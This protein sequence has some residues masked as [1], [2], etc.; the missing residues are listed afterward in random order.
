M[1]DSSAIIAVILDEP[2][3]SIVM[4][5]LADALVSAPMVAEAYAVILRKM[6]T[7]RSVD[8]FFD[9]KGVKVVPLSFDQAKMAGHYE[10]VGR[11]VGLSLGDRCCLSLAYEKNVAVLTADRAWMNVAKKIGVD[12]R[13]IR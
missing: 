7:S 3:A 13:M 5:E 8:S 1:L 12:V 2:G 6:Q 9:L 11:K 10:S 4:E